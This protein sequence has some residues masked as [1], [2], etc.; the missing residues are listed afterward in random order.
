MRLQ[1]LEIFQVCIPFRFSF[2]HA[3]AERKQADSVLIKITDSDGFIGWGES[4]PRTYLTGETVATV[5]EDLAGKWW[6]VFK[7][8]DFSDNTSPL[9]VLSPVFL[10]ADKE[11]NTASYTAFDL[12]LYDLV[13]KRAG[14]SISQLL[15]YT[16]KESIL[17]APLGGSLKGIKRKGFLFRLLG[18]KEYKAKC[19]LGAEADKIALARKIIGESADL[20]VDAN[21]AWDTETALQELE[22]LK[23]YNLSSI[24][25]PCKA[26][27]ELAVVQKNSGLEV[28]ADESLCSLEGAREII[29]KNAASI[30]NIRLAKLGGFTGV[31]HYLKL[32]K[33]YNIKL[34]LGTLVGETSLLA[35][36]GRA[37][38]GSAE[39][40]HVEYGFPRILL[41]DDPFRGGAAGYFGKG[42]PRG[43]ALGLGVDVEEKSL[44]RITTQCYS[45][46]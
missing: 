40:K 16:S 41:K 46:D 45:L 42:E 9:D 13:A 19:G 33:H 12:A 15:H 18:F 3:L 21:A 35:A 25:Q 22:S 38:T 29:E 1:K 17:T 28:M 4:V 34:H 14:K 32:A 30:W 5:L 7:G 11:N 27:E 24:E 44:Q 8:L 36:A 37:L 10:Q 2:K 43:G 26:I 39:F 6:D 20:R 31:E 23:K